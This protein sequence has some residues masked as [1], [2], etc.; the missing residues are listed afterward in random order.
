MRIRRLALAA[1]A[2]ALLAGCDATEPARPGVL[3]AHL[4]G[5]RPRDAALVLTI[6]GPALPAEVS[7]EQGYVV[8]SRTHA[9]AT[10]VAVFGDIAGGPLVRFTIPDAKLADRFG[11]Q[12]REV[13]DEEYTLRE[14]LTPYTVQLELQKPK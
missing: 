3:T 11:V 1:G 4:S 7:A 2:A 13:A 8:H 10:S 14:D 6:S 12:L 9:G 5:T